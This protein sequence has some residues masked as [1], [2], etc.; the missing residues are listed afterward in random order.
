M[1]Q[2]EFAKLPT[3]FSFTQITTLKDVCFFYEILCVIK[4]WKKVFHQ[5]PLYH[6]KSTP[7]YMKLTKHEIKFATQPCYLFT[8]EKGIQEFFTIILFIYFFIALTLLPLADFDHCQE[9]P[10]KLGINQNIQYTY[11]ENCFY[12]T[13]LKAY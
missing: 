3:L 4:P 10:L 7:Y 5:I 2:Q 11:T 6:Q 12:Y 1:R 9:C 8:V 13:F